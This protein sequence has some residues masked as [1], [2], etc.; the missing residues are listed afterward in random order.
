MTGVLV[1]MSDQLT[2]EQ[3]NALAA[4]LQ[5]RFPGVRFAIVSGCTALATFEFDDE[6]EAT[7]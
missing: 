2:V 3:A 1:G 4:L 7:S 6:P 5:R